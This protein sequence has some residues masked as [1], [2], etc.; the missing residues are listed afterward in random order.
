MTNK[1]AKSHEDERET[2]SAI[3]WPSLLNPEYLSLKSSWEAFLKTLAHLPPLKN[4]VIL[5]LGCGHKPL[6]SLFEQKRS[7]YIGVD[8]NLQVKPV[9][10]MAAERLAITA[11]AADVILATAILEHVQDPQK[12]TLEI[13]RI[14]KPGGLTIIQTHGAYPYHPNPVDHWRWT[15]TGLKLLLKKAGLVTIVIYPSGNTLVTYLTSQVGMLHV[16]MMK[17][18]L[19]AYLRFLIVPLANIAALLLTKMV[20][21]KTAFDQPGNL[22]ISYTILAQKPPSPPYRVVPD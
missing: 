20:S 3:P 13:E 8:L 9:A 18:A 19:T 11:E 15:H 7:K 4:K 21:P 5:D 10:V 6:K 14:L 17:T 1:V 16:I 22:I 2:T 12:T